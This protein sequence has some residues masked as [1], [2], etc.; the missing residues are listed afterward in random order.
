MT[1]GGQPKTIFF[2][3]KNKILCGC[4][5]GVLGIACAGFMGKSSDDLAVH[6][7]GTFTSVQGGDGKLMQWKPL[8]T[9][10]LP[11]FV[12]D[13][14]KPGLNRQVGGI[15]AF[16]KGAMTSLQRMETPVIYFYSKKEQVVDVNVQFPK[17]TITEWY[18]QVAEIGPSSVPRNPL[19]LSADKTIHNTGVLQNF[20]VA[21]YFGPDDITNS[22]AH[23]ADILISPALQPDGGSTLPT[24]TTGSHYFAARETD[25]L[26]AR[27]SS[28][29]NSSYEYDKFLFYRGIGNFATPLTVLMPTDKKI[30]LTNTGPQ[31]LEHLFVVTVTANGGNFEHLGKLA[32]GTSKMVQVDTST[33]QLDQK[34]F[35]KRLGAELESSLVQQGLFPKEAKAMV[36]TWEESWL[37]EQGTRVL[38]ILPR[39]WT[40]STLPIT[41]KP[42]P[43]DLVRVMVG[44]AELIPPGTQNRLA[45]NLFKAGQGDPEAASE[46]QTE[47]KTLGRFAEPAFYKALESVTSTN[48]DRARLQKLLA[49]VETAN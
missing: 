35:K 11:G 13:W 21:D 38:Y 48:I 20:S 39:A 18:P 15:L 46:A 27:T 37:G 49:K 8:Q 31:N 30:V 26:F 29:T 10:K 6:E 19:L 43:K 16:G 5:L 36:K 14:R 22:M 28:A 23:W 34:T 45:Q 24:D 7:W 47:L 3:M 2:R 41:I 40:D 17:G 12:H 44:R 42:A 9:S 4:L 1:T 33:P 32:K 25:A